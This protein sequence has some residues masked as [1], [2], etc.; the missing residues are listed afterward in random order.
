MDEDDEDFKNFDPKKFWAI[1]NQE[2]ISGLSQPRKE[3]RTLENIIRFLKDEHF[4]DEI[5]EEFNISMASV[6]KYL[7]S[8]RF[9]KGVSLDRKDCKGRYSYKVSD[10]RRS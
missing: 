6:N 9:M 8:L 3:S 1:D 2:N 5:K 7:V 4:A 10:F